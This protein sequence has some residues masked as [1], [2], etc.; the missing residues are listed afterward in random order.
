MIRKRGS[1]DGDSVDGFAEQALEALGNDHVVGN[2]GIDKGIVDKANDSRRDVNLGHLFGSNWR[3]FSRIWVIRNQPRN[4]QLLTKNE[5]E[6]EICKRVSGASP[7]SSSS[8]R[9][10]SINLKPSRLEM[11]RYSLVE[12]IRQ[13]SL[14]QNCGLREHSSER[15]DR[16]RVE[17]QVQELACNGIIALCTRDN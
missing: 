9:I 3:E 8:E 14:F 5:V 7:A 6:N 1:N 4:L 16:V 17:L 10:R 13:A 15:M 2:F 11:Q 12:N